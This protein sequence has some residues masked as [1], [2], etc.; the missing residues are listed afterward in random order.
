MGVPLGQPGKYSFACTVLDEGLVRVGW[1]KNDATLQLGTDG[2]G[3]GYGG[4]GVKV[5]NGNYDPYPNEERLAFGKG[6][7]IGCHLEV[8][9]MQPKAPNT[10]TVARISYKKN[11]DDLGVAFE[12]AKK[13]MRTDDVMFPTVCLKNAQCSLSF[14]S[15][16][17]STKEF[18][19]C[20][21]NAS[22]SLIRNQRDSD[23]EED[24]KGPLAVIIE[25]TR[26]LAEQTFRAFDDLAVNLPNELEVRSALLVGG[27]SPKETNSMLQKDRVDVLVGTPPI[28]AS[29]IKKGSVSCSKCRFFVLDEADE[30]ISNNSLQDVRSIYSRLVAA[31]TKSKSRFERLQVCFFSATLHSKEVRQLSDEI[32][33][34]PFWVDLRGKDNSILPETVHHCFIDI[35]PQSF[36][37]AMG[38]LSTDAVHRK[39][40]L[41]TPVTLKGLSEKESDS[42]KVKQL[43][44][45]AVRDLIDKFGMDQVLIFCRTNLDCE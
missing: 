21:N 37:T 7:T 39:G 19:K 22:G 11:E 4:T 9:A 35:Q 13:S 38:F 16:A 2:G 24:G 23:S 15:D 14:S 29:Y 10:A 5:N 31:H 30:L 32:C 3:Y 25:P 17:T 26:D 18:F 12:I 33:L 28:V 1:S 8:L 36:D 45:R 34:Q 40:K 27:I 44:L 41:E 43:K 6:D 42:E 20:L